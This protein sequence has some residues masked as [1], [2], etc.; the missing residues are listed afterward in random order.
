VYDDYVII[1]RKHRILY[2]RMLK[3]LYGMLMSSVLY[4]KKFRKDI[5]SVGF[6]VSPYDIC[7]ANRKV[8]GKQQTVMWHVNG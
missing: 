1:E 5:E 3:A 4:Y 7:V 2:V 6:E 8:N